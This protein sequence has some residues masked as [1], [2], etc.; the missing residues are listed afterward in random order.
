MRRTV[1][2]GGREAPI[3]P[4]TRFYLFTRVVFEKRHDVR[5]RHRTARP[6]LVEKTALFFRETTDCLCMV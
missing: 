2:L 3:P 5:R 1:C 4:P 6:Q